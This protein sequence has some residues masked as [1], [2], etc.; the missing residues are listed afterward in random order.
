MSENTVEGCFEL[1]SRWLKENGGYRERGGI[2]TDGLVMWLSAYQRLQEGASLARALEEF[3]HSPLWE[4]AGDCKRTIERRISFNT[5]GFAQARQNLKLETAERACDELFEWLAKAKSAEVNQK[6]LYSVDGSS[7]EVF[8]TKKVFQKYPSHKTGYYPQMRILVCHDLETGLAVRPEYGAMRGKHAQG[9]I[10]LFKKMV[11]RLP[12]RSTL[13]GDRNFGIFAVAY[14]AQKKGFD[15]VLRLMEPRAQKAL[16]RMPTDGTDEEVQ[17]QISPKERARNNPEIPADATVKGRIICR[18]VKSYN[19]DKTTRLILFTT[20]QETADEVIQKY[21][22]RWNIE[23]DLRTL[24][25]T[26]NMHMLCVKSEQMAHKELI[27]GVAAYNLVCSVMKTAADA[28]G[29]QPRNFSFKRILY[30]VNSTARHYAAAA[31]D[32]ER[33]KW[34]VEQLMRTFNAAKHPKRKRRRT[35]PRALVRHPRQKFPS[36]K[37]SRANARKSMAPKN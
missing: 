31:G 15:V 2:Y 23:T 22:Q 16:G 12:E 18:D 7:I 1:F 30:A 17:W 4:L 6:R 11:E 33:Q 25:Q 32:A 37:G 14:Y 9:E 28:L 27:L 19:G 10:Q 5:G 21:G 26:V 24:K 8:R 34:L 35:E 20:L 13:V 3:E 36:L 29:L